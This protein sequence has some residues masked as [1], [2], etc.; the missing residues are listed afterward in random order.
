M[1]DDHLVYSF[2]KNRR[3]QV[4]ASLTEYR[5]HQLA[6]VRVYVVDDLG[7]PIATKK[8]LSVRVEDLP[9][10]REAVDA[11]IDEQSR[12]AA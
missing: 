4:R 10:L 8:G 7:Q 9:R 1:I 3:E 6:D 5:G 12:R 11:L 2:P